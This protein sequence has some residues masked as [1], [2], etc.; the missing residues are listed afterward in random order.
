MELHDPINPCICDDGSVPADSALVK[1]NDLW[2]EAS[3]KLGAPLNS[4][5]KYEEQLAEAGFT[6]IVKHEY[7][8]PSNDWPKNRHSKV[9][10]EYFSVRVE[11][12]F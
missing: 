5:L 10:G 6:N 3:T 4:A 11:F 8:W 12:C 7:Y 9:L 1:W 2:L